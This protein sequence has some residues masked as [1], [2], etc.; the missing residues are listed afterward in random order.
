VSLR[1][2]E[3]A[4]PSPSVVCLHGLAGHSREWDALAAVLD[5]RVL[6]PDLRGHGWSDWAQSYSVDAHVRDVA[7]VVEELVGGPAIVVGHSLGG[8]VA[9]SLAADHPDLV[10]GL[11]V[12]DIGSELPDDA[13]AQALNSDDRPD[14]FPDPQ[15]AVAA[16]RDRNPFSVDESLQRRVTYGLVERSP[17]R[18][19]WRH[20]PS[21]E[22]PQ[23]DA[24]EGMWE[25][26]C[27]V[28]TPSLVVRGE[29]S[30]WLTPDLMAR[31][32]EAR[33]DVDVVSIAGAGHNAHTDQP[34]PFHQAVIAWLVHT[35]G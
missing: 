32:A 22:V 33:A 31:M 19:I 4:G 24:L 21:A 29:H 30:P 25:R 7:V 28:R 13:V 20:D 6:A 15:A 34:D 18:W 23:P 16:L 12:V 5:G 10:E 11:V 26:W 27:A 17:D 3:W 8:I 9:M 35:A 14:S 1:V 2:T